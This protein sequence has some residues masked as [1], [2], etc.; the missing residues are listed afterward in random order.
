MAI[1]SPRLGVT[2]TA[3]ASAIT[4]RA[5]AGLF[6]GRPPYFLPA[7]AYRS[8]GLE[9]FLVFCAGDDVPGFTLDPARQ[10]A[11]CSNT[12]AFPVPRVTFVDRSFRFPQEL[13]LSAGPAVV[14]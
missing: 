10:P 2:Y 6:T 8:T 11:A 7:D 12:G 13:K 5:G 4:L 9:Q 14:A 1:W 3:G